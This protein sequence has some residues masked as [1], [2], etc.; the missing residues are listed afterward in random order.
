MLE[1]AGAPVLLDRR[2]AAGERCR[3]TLARV[4]R[5]WTRAA[6]AWRGGR[7]RPRPRRAGAADPGR[8]R[9]RHLHL[10]LDRPAQGGGG[11][12]RA[13]WSRLLR[14]HAAQS[15]GFGPDDVWTLFHSLAFDFSVWELWGALAYGGR[16]VVVPRRGRPLAGGVRRAAARERVTVLSQTPSAFRQLLGPRRRPSRARGAARGLRLVVFGGEALELARAAPWLERHGDERRRLVNMYGIT[17][18]TVHVDLPAR[19]RRRDLA[20][21]R[22]R[23]SAGRIAGPRGLRCSTARRGRC[24]SACRASSHVGGAGRGARLPRPPGADRGALRARPVRRRRGRARG[25]T[26]PATWRAGA[27]DGD[28]EYLGRIDHQVKV[29]GFRIELGEIEAALAEH[30]GV[31]EAVVL[32]R[33]DAPGRRAAGRLRGAR[34]A[35]PTGRR[36]RCARSSPSA[37]PG[38]HGAGGLRAPRPRCRSPPTARWTARPCPRPRSAATAAR[39]GT[40]P[41]EPGRAGARRDLGGGARAA[42]GSASTTTSSPWAA[43]RS[44]PPR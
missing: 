7:R 42:S 12:A 19:W 29:R 15:F 24:R 21:R 38:L 31:R 33:E 18:T 20:R 9:L 8:P 25:S 6:P 41:R 27:P 23:R 37:L 26:A 43:T 39:T 13:T 10:G 22:Q 5:A 34:R 11:D 44:S 14:R 1:D 28:L 17:E 36:G 32:A 4:G 16:L 35:A 2:S 3:R 40:A 30:P